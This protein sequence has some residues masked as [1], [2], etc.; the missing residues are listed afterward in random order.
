MNMLIVAAIEERRL[1]KLT[2]SAGNRIVE[3]HVYGV[4]SD[5][6]EL[7]RCYQVGGESLSRERYGWKLLHSEEM[8]NVEVLD[9]AFVPRT[10]YNPEDPAIRR[11]YARL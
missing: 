4:G 9:V 11:V 10:D 2:Y 8:R 6:R 7:L 3:P 5:G 1:L